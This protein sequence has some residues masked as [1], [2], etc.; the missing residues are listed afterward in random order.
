MDSD[1]EYKLV[2]PDASLAD[3]VYCFSSMRNLSHFGEGDHHSKRE[4]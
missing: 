3:F 2:K 4:S 1:L